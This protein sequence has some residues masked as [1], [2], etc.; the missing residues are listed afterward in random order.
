MTA[1]PVII[2]CCSSDD[3]ELNEAAAAATAEAAAIT[4][5]IEVSNV[6]DESMAYLLT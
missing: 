5:A 3:L 1:L 4:V 6:Y 2:Y